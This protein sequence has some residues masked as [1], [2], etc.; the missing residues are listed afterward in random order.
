MCIITNS[1]R[2]I[3]RVSKFEMQNSLSIIDATEHS[4]ATDLKQSN[5]H[6]D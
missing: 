1:D 2:N 4:I 6:Y 3:D 5:P